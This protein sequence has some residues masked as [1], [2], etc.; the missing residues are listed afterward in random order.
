MSDDEQELP[1]VPV[2]TPSEDTVEDT[3]LFE[4]SVP[5]D[6]QELDLTHYR[7]KR[8]P[9]DITRF[10]C[11][12]R[13]C[14]RQNLLSSMRGIE[15]LYTVM[16]LD[17][18][19]NRIEQVECLE[20]MTELTSLDLS[21]NVIKSIGTSLKGLSK[22]ESLYMCQNKISVVEGLET[23]QS[24]KIL[25]LGA[26]RIRTIEHL[27]QI[28][29][30]TQLYMGKNKLTTLLGMEAL[31]NLTLVSLQSNRITKI[32][33]LDTLVNLE[34]LY[35]SHN[36]IQVIEGLDKNLKLTMLDLGNN[37]ISKVENLSHLSCLTEFWAS[38]N[39]ISSFA[40][41]EQELKGM[42][43]LEAVY[44]EGNPLEKDPQYRLKLKLSLPT[45]KQI[46]A[47]FVRQ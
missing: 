19:D 11:L 43:T 7:L 31:T 30:L 20:Q 42:L 14:M 2:E 16:D 29:Q 17:F 10:A 13:L 46:D 3:N 6:L 36:G 21:F 40:E 25:E 28:P 45:L 32:E 26:N 4:D 22:L 27:S 24:L 1:V 34:E 38:G 5:T 9:A 8:V 35:L 39:Q 47:T 37:R 18:Y 23:L 41:V 33:G 44:L 15:T 12:T